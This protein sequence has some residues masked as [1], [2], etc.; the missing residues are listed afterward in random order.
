M[1]KEGQKFIEMEQ[2]LQ[3]W[4]IWFSFFLRDHK[5]KTCRVIT[6]PT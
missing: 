3:L 6:K 5:A 2:Q 1:D 4:S